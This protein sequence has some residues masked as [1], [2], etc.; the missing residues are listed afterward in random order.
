MPFSISKGTLTLRDEVEISSREPV[1]L[2]LL[3]AECVS[4]REEMFR[5]RRATEPLSARYTDIRGSQGR[6]ES[7]H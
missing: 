6:V 4:E 7:R 1:V 2:F 3:E 5:V